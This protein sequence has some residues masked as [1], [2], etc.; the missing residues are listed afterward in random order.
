MGVC[1]R[2]SAFGE[3]GCLRLLLESA[4]NYQNLLFRFAGSPKI[5]Y[6]GVFIRT[7][8]TIVYGSSQSQ[9]TIQNK[10]SIALDLGCRVSG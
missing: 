8:N 7:D 5:L 10:M 2:S 9:A 1:S 6:Q 4:L 3:G